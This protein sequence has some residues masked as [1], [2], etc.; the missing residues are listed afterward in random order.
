MVLHYAGEAPWKVSRVTRMLTDTQLLWFDACAEVFG[1]TK[2]RSLR[3]FYQVWEIV[4]YR[5]IFLTIF[6]IPPLQALF[7]AWLRRTGRGP[8]CPRSGRCER[9]GRQCF[10]RRREPS[11]RL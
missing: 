9:R 2:W 10:R 8:F 3:K 6:R 5:A 4:A 11:A 7:R 1:E